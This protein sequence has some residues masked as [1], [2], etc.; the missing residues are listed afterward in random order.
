MGF[1]IGGIIGGLAGAA[2][3]IAG[4]F[5]DSAEDA[6]NAQEAAA[7]RMEARLDASADEIAGYAEDYANT[8]DKMNA[9]FD[10]YDI[11]SAFESLYEGVILP[12]ERDFAEFVLPSVHAAYSGGVFGAESFQ[13]GAAKESA[14]RAEQRLSTAKGELRSQERDRAVDVNMS[15]Q[16]QKLASE[17][18]KLQARTMA[19]NVRADSAGSIFQAQSAAIES[20]YAA[21]RSEFEALTNIPG[22]I[23]SGATGGATIGS[24]FGGGT[25]KGSSPV[26]ANL[27]K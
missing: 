20:R 5:D 11:E 15:V 7:R 19:P 12:M 1:S 21:D 18:N 17:G 24:L 8:L 4:L 3:G 16:Q 6:A 26:R 27:I 23:V 14:L 2:G 25:K 22:A 10:P 13:S 9:T